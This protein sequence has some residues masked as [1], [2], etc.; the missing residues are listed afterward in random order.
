VLVNA[1]EDSQMSCYVLAGEARHASF[2]SAGSLPFR[3][4]TD[5]SRRH[6]SKTSFVPQ[7]LSL[8][9]ETSL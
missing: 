9:L 8:M 3:V 1:L 2:L 5:P 7:R 6:A 4:S